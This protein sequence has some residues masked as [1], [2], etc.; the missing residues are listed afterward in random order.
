MYKHLHVHGQQNF[1]GT[2]RFNCNTEM[3]IMVVRELEGGVEAHKK[4]T[5]MDNP[6]PSTLDHFQRSC[7]KGEFE[8]PH[9]PC[10]AKAKGHWKKCR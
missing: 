2:I 7:K 3:Y 8:Q 5:F 9:N 1:W 10:V 6:L 4:G